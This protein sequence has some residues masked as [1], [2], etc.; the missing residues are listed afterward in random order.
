M[1]CACLCTGYWLDAV[2]PLCT[3]TGYWLDAVC[4]H[5]MRE[6]EARARRRITAVA[7]ARTVARMEAREA[8][9]ARAWDALCTYGLGPDRM[10]LVAW[11][12]ACR[13][14]EAA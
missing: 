10:R 9:E 4:L 13:A 6:R 2:C 5:H 14:L 11:M 12:R 1:S 8:A 7:T 3:S